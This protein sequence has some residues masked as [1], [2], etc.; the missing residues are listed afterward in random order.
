MVELDEIVE[1]FDKLN[2]RCMPKKK[3]EDTVQYKHDYVVHSRGFVIDNDVW[4]DEYN[5]NMGHNY[6]WNKHIGDEYGLPDYNGEW[7][8]YRKEHFDE[9][10]PMPIY[11][12]ITGSNVLLVQHPRVE[13]M[14]G[15]TVHRLK[16]LV[17]DFELP[18][19]FD[20]RLYREPP[21]SGNSHA[22]SILR[23]LDSDVDKSV[24]FSTQEFYDEVQP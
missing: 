19:D 17:D 16:M 14:D 10:D 6:F 7:V 24:T 23:A 21:D 9:D 12:S 1:K 20:I 15:E 2:W 18:D 22:Q 4:F 3:A 8:P 5:I 11:F 13:W